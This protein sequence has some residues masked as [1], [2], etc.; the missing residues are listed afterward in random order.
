MQYLP[1]DL[2]IFDFDGV[3][4]DSEIISVELLL[5]YLSSHGVQ[6]S[7][8]EAY[9]VFLGKQISKADES[10]QKAMG[11]SVPPLDE[12]SF[13]SELF[14]R[15]RSELAP[16]D[17][18]EEVFRDLSLPMCIASSSSPD[19]IDA[20]LQMTGLDRAFAGHRFG[21]GTVKNGKPAPDLFLHAA[22]FHKT[23][24][25]RCVVIEDSPSGLTAAKAAGMKSI[26]FL[27]GSHAKL[28]GLESKLAA[29]QP[30]RII[31][32]MAELPGAIESIFTA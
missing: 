17:G 9:D 18:I 21:A 27:G 11:I 24:P 26:G 10:L 19:R 32:S 20:S 14:D 28:A 1:P 5:E 8:E 15:F 3:V 6:I 16:I 2:V 22:T 29:L 13:K 31:S 4:V 12:V 30:D 7:S 25:D 23:N